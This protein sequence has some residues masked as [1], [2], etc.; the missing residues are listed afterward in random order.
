MKD[1]EHWKREG[2]A[3]VARFPNEYE[4]WVN[5]KTMQNLRRYCDGREWLSD[6]ATGEYILVQESK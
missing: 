1:I 6:L 2:F 5:R 4:L 3:L